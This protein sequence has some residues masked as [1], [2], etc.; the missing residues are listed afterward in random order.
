MS[1]KQLHHSHSKT[2]YSLH[3]V[4]YVSDAAV[5]DSKPYITDIRKKQLR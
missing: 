4:D 2:T 1:F 5:I 3:I